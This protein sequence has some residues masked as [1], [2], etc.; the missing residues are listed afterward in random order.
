[1]LVSSPALKPQRHGAA[2]QIAWRWPRRAE[3]TC[4]TGQEW[5]E[6]NHQDARAPAEPRGGLDARA[7]ACL[8]WSCSPA[9]PSGEAEGSSSPALGDA[10][11]VWCRRNEV[12]LNEA[13]NVLGLEAVP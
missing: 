9:V 13:A 2:A 3:S 12:A 4:W 10:A 5:A 7:A 11:R 6:P 1:M 8:T